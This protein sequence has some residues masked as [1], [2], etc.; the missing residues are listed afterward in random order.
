MPGRSLSVIAEFPESGVSRIL[1]LRQGFVAPSLAFAVL[2][3]VMAISAHPAFAQSEMLQK[4]PSG[5]IRMAVINP[6]SPLSPFVPTAGNV[7]N[8]Y[9]KEKWFD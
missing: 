3:S 1:V 2:E 5:R 7:A 8:H 6:R 9:A 4:R